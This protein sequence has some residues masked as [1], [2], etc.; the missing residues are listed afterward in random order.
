MLEYVCVCVWG[1]G[2]SGVEEG[3]KRGGGGGKGRSNM[4]FT[5]NNYEDIQILVNMKT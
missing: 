3:G 5:V 4:I 1:G 2:G